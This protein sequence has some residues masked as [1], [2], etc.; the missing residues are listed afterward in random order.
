M[1]ERLASMAL[2]L[3]GAVVWV[4][5]SSNA[6]QINDSQDQGSASDV[7][8][9]VAPE[10]LAQDAASDSDQNSN[11]ED[12]SEASD[13]LDAVLDQ[14]PGDLSEMDSVADVPGD[15]AQDLISQDIDLEA[16]ID[17]VIDIDSMI[18]NWP[19]GEVQQHLEG[20]LLAE[21]QS[22]FGPVSVLVLSG[23]H[24]QIGYQHGL[25]VAD[26]LAVFFQ[27]FLEYYLDD[28]E[29]LAAEL[30]LPPGNAIGLL[31][32]VLMTV[33]DHMAPYVSEEALAEFQG[34]GEGIVASGID[35]AG[36]DPDQV[37][38]ALLVLSNISDLDW[39]GSVE[40]LLNKINEGL[41]TTLIAYFEGTNQSRNVIPA[42]LRYAS[43]AFSRAMS[44]PSRFRHTCSFF[45][46]WGA[47]STD[48]HYVG[49]RNLDW[50]TDT[51]IVNMRGLLFY[52]PKGETPHLAIGYL[53]FV[54][55]LAG[56]NASG[57]V[58]SEVGSES[59]M[60]RLKGEPWGMKF[61]RILGAAS[62]LD[63]AIDIALG[64]DE[65]DKPHPLTIGYNFGL[66]FGDPE[67]AGVGA[68]GA[69]LETNG[70]RGGLY[71]HHP[72]C[73][74]EA[75]LVEFDETG[76]PKVIATHLSNPGLANLEADAFEVGPDAEPKLFLVDD[77]GA[78]VL[79]GGYPTLSPS[80][81]PYPVGRP[82]ACAFYRGDEAL[83]HGVRMWQKAANGPQG[84]N[85]LVVSSGSYQ[86]R[87]LRSKACLD[88]IGAGTGYETWVA[89]NQ[90]VPRTV[91]LVEGEWV[92]RAAAMGSNVLS[93]VYDAT[94]LTL[95][96]SW[97]QGS[98]E[99]WKNAQGH[100]YLYVDAGQVFQL[101]TTP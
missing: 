63:Q 62:S 41:S 42:V 7:S 48:G 55:S 101:G 91:G 14:R 2:F 10:V 35:V 26:R 78:F 40:D 66:G 11:P 90:G 9:E 21:M 19:L 58:L 33:W 15:L 81:S 84:A 57:V 93:V 96:V 27:T 39:G 31:Q 73:T 51:G 100:E 4:A 56:M 43:G 61:R 6:T 8:V 20:A 1:R 37:G 16:D 98:G 36:W 13:Q 65:P 99:T 68:C 52:F 24:Y 75:S 46:V 23:S 59:A 80:G 87:Y 97:E 18:A 29:E 28:F 94:A 12:L 67:G 38:K 34:F 83:M 72:D 3:A 5:C 79:S 50:S 30:G 60:E 95:R 45:G 25:L 74:V 53:G 32:S 44:R 71:R 76:L 49:S 88:A 85:T 47:R 82:T 64:L 92:A 17:P 86:S 70:L 54:G 89:D 22:P 77:E 69:V